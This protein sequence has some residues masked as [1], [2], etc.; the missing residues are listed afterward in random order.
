MV[1]IRFYFFPFPFLQT[2]SDS[3]AIPVASLTLEQLMEAVGAVYEEMHHPLPAATDQSVTP[4]QSLLTQSATPYQV[5][6][7]AVVATQQ[8]AVGQSPS[9]LPSKLITPLAELMDINNGRG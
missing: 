7:D 8:S 6:S 9:V 5:I 1:G 3:G 4:Y 2:G